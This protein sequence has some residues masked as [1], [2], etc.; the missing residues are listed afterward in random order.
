MK[1][2]K[3][4]IDEISHHIHTLISWEDGGSITKQNAKGDFVFDRIAAN[5]L[6]RTMAKLYQLAKN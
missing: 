2:S 5:R 3:K 6:T 4:E 1:I